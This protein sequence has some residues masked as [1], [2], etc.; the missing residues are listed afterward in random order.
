MN[1]IR[2]TQPAGYEPTECYI[3]PDAVSCV[4]PGLLS[5]HPTLVTNMCG[6]KFYVAASLHAVLKALGDS[7]TTDLTGS[8]QAFDAA[9][10][11]AEQHPV[12]DAPPAAIQGES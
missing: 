7:A 4:A 12:T 1:L 5:S 8:A 3:N 6:S 9:A 2:I 10:K 11:A